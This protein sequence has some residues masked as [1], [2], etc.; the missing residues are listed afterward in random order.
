MNIK[1]DENTRVVSNQ[2][3]KEYLEMRHKRD[4]IKRLE[5]LERLVE[6]QAREIAALKGQEGK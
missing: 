6:S 1:V 4:V 5:K 3:R 2:N